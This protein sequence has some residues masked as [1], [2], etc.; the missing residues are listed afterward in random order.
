MNISIFSASN[1]S[2]LNFKRKKTCLMGKLNKIIHPHVTKKHY[3]FEIPVDLKYLSCTF[4]LTWLDNMKYYIQGN[5]LP[6]LYFSHF[7]CFSQWTHFKMA[8]SIE[9]CKLL[10]L[11]FNKHSQ[12]KTI[13]Q[14]KI[15][16]TCDWVKIALY[17]ITLVILKQLNVLIFLKYIMLLM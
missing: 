3:I 5:C 12:L 11:S 10:V 2:V 7:C 1:I 14:D 4:S 15:L 13:N 9:N 8:L 16:D 17:A 6:S